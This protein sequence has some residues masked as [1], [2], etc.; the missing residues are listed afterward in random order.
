[1]NKQ[2]QTFHLNP[3]EHADGAQEFLRFFQL[4]PGKANLAL[5]QAILECS[6]RIPYEN[7]SKIITYS[8]CGDVVRPRIRLPET[9]ISDHIEH[10]LGGTCFSLTFLLQ[11]VLTHCGFSC[12]P[13]MAD[14]KAGKNVHCCL[15]VWMDSVKYLVDL[16]Y[17]LTTPMA[18][19]PFK[20]EHFRNNFAR[21]Q[22]RPTDWHHSYDLLT[23]DKRRTRW[24]YRFHDRPVSSDEFPQHWLTSFGRNAMHGI[25]LTKTLPD[26]LLFVNRNFMR[27]TT[28]EGKRNY[29]IRRTY[30][31]TIFEHFGIEAEIVEQAQAALAFTLERAD[32]ARP[33]LLGNESPALGAASTSL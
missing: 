2:L 27:E 5:L 6:A 23:C 22:I 31:A 21:V 11:T 7:I 3:E 19:N 4:S 28:F 32:A 10:H 17:L 15:I 30:H 14:M 25:C 12:Y 1:M 33:G 29:N 18:L 13:V 26:G 8:R 16:G 9:V 24:R 20:A